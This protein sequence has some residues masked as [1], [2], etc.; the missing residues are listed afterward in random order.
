MLAEV[1]QSTCSRLSTL[2]FP[3]LFSSELPFYH[4]D[5]NEALEE[6]ILH[7]TRPTMSIDV[8]ERA[9]KRGLTLQ[10]GNLMR[11]CWNADPRQRPTA[12]LLTS[13]LHEHSQAFASPLFHPGAFITWAQ[14]SK[15]TVTFA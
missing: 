14:K 13:L 5:D 3:K 11:A 15:L 9:S 10:T 7:G 4:I 6:E 8:K 2:T 12:T 1:S